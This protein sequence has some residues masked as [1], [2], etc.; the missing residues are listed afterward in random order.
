MNYK[1]MIVDDSRV[2]YAEIQKLLEGSEFHIVGYCRSGEAALESYESLNPD[3]VTM[4][5]VMPGMDGLETC[6]KLRERWPDARILM[7]SSLA[8]SATME[9]SAEMGAKGFIFK[10]FTQ[11]ELLSG[12][13][14]AVSDCAS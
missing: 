12:L 4:D 7:V 9:A 3:V 13:R 6:Q 14:K 2:A 1:L 8:Y 5:I 10:P 11:E